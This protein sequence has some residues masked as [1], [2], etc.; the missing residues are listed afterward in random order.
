MKHLWI[1]GIW[2]AV[3]AC[4]PSGGGNHDGGTSETGGS[5]NKVEASAK[6]SAMGGELV[7]K[8]DGREIVAV[9]KWRAYDAAKDASVSKW[10]GDMGTPPPAFVVD[11]LVLAIDGKG[12]SIPASKYRYLGSKWM[13]QYSANPMSFN[14]QGDKMRLLVDVGDGG[15]GWTAVYVFDPAA[16]KLL[17]HSVDDGPA[18]H[19]QI[20]P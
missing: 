19:D 1:F 2:A 4:A 14:K 3:A 10:Y 20:L 13:N 9:I 7:A 15:E 18:V 11:R 12:V 8:Q 17:S 5:W 16:G 6:S